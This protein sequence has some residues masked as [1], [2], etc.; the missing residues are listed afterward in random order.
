MAEFALT[1]GSWLLSFLLHSALWC[2]GALLLLRLRPNWPAQAR[3]FVV[4]GAVLGGFLTATLPFLLAPMGLSTPM[5]SL[6]LATAASESMMVELPRLPGQASWQEPLQLEVQLTSEQ[7]GPVWWLQTLLGLWV[8]GGL[9]A[10]TR[11][12]SSRRRLR[13]ILRGR[14]E[15]VDGQLSQSV[16]G[17]LAEMPA[18]CRPRVYLSDSL[19]VPIAHGH[20]R[21]EVVLPRRLLSELSLSAQRSV[22]AHELGHLVRRDPLW[23]LTLD[24]VGRL[25]WLQPLLLPLRKHARQASEESADA[26]A[27]Q[28]TGDGL[29]LADGLTRIASWLPEP[30]PALAAAT[31]LSNNSGL[32]QRVRRLLAPSTRS[33]VP[34]LG[35]GL[36]L[37]AT[38]I[39]MTTPAFQ[40]QVPQD[41]NEEIH[42]VL[43]G[44]EQAQP[45]QNRFRF[46]AAEGDWGM[47]Q[48]TAMNPRAL[49]E[50]WPHEGHE[51]ELEIL[52]LRWISEPPIPPTPP[53]PPEIVELTTLPQAPAAPDF[54]QIRAVIELEHH[55]ERLEKEEQRMHQEHRKYQV[56]VT[57][58][59]QPSTVSG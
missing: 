21:P 13:E 34:G 35:L 40:A 27:A 30:M 8:F 4:K 14:E 15:L 6:P 33:Q 17:L 44:L 55:L 52:G 49:A 11:L 51:Q 9:V 47:A 48:A 12:V 19:E 16:Q 23:L 53:Q 57:R 45:E 5:A 26:W 20:W 58:A 46:R 2:G 42:Y 36:A 29:S 22:V 28:A 7:G 43:E 31:A 10:V 41:Q 39:S 25:F 38:T 32:G 24:M 3:D 54:P 56:I 59:A 1:L 50:R 18:A 37:F